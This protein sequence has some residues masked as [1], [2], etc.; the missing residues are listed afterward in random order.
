[1]TGLALNQ[2]K[3][4]EGADTKILL[5][6]PVQFQ[7]NFFRFIKPE[8]D[9][10]ISQT[11]FAGIAQQGRIRNDGQTTLGW[12]IILNLKVNLSF[13]NN[14]DSRP[15]ISGG[16]KFDYGYNFGVGYTFN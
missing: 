2:E 10:G 7:F 9:L 6:V 13:H 16:R 8:V 1:M 5:D 4:T 12:E 11:V 15:P 3:N 14:Y